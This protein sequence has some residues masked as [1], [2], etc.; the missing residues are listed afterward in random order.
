MR[1]PPLLSSLSSPASPLLSGCAA[2]GV[3]I[4]CPLCPPLPTLQ[5]GRAGPGRAE[6]ERALAGRAGTREALARR[7]AALCGGRLET[8]RGARW[9]HVPPCG[10]G[11][12]GA[13]SPWGPQAWAG[14]G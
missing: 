14:I 11:L 8:L 3:S 4:E 9:G 12:G 1:V 5:V 7:E 13:M 6:R 2:L 10:V